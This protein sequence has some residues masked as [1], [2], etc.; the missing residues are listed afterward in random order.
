MRQS[1]THR[2]KC[3]TNLVFQHCMG[4]G[5]DGGAKES[6]GNWTDDMEH[7]MCRLGEYFSGGLVVIEGSLRNFL[8]GFGE[9]WEVSLGDWL[10][11]VWDM[12][13]KFFG[14]FERCLDSS[15]EVF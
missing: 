12:F 14:D 9:V 13:G 15:R 5:V 3:G 1:G 7:L 4:D 10:R 8:G 2:K 11:G 6:T